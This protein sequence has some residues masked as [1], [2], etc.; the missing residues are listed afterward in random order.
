MSAATRDGNS[1][2]ASKGL[3]SRRR[4]RW[5]WRLLSSLMLHRWRLVY[6]A[7]PV[8][9]LWRKLLSM[10]SLSKRLQ[11]LDPTVL[12]AYDAW[13]LDSQVWKAF[14]ETVPT[15]CILK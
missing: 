6:L 2:E 4:T 8:D 1:T 12:V 15:V 11:P 10:T 14:S 13:S 3:I 9:I 7:V 5:P